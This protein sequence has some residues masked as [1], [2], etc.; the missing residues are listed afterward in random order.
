MYY[1]LTHISGP[2]M[3]KSG[4]GL[5]G[6][7]RPVLIGQLPNCDVQLPVSDIYE[8]QVFAVILPREEAS[9]W[10]LVRRTDHFGIT[11]DG[12]PLHTAAPLKDNAVMAFDWPCHGEDARKTLLLQDCDFYLLYL[13]HMCIF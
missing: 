6:G 5:L 12:E 1:R 3:A 9:G 2:R 10:L 8:P 11:I 4:Q 13:Q 7:D